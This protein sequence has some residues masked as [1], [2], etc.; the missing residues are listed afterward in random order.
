MSASLELLYLALVG[1][2]TID[3]DNLGL[4]V[5]GGQFH[6]FGNLH[7]QFTGG[8]NNEHLHTGARVG[9]EALNDGQTK[10]EGLTRARLGLADDVLT[11][12]GQGDGLLLNGE[13]V[14]NSLGSQRFNNVSVDV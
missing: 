12:Q 10:T 14:C 7:T 1:L 9:S 4:T 13:W 2:A 11:A 5:G 3:G 6:I 8:H